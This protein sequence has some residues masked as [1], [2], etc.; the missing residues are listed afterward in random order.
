[1]T[2]R[3]DEVETGV[4][5]LGGLRGLAEHGW[6]PDFHGM[7]FPEFHCLMRRV[8]AVRDWRDFA[9]SLSRRLRW[10]WW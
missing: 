4:I 10:L 7:A 8:C 3:A 6:M 2:L 1:M 5:G 9:E